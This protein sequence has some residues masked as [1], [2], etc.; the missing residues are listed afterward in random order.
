MEWHPTRSRELNGGNDDNRATYCD[1]IGIGRVEVGEAGRTG[2]GD[3][4]PHYAMD[5]ED[6]TRIW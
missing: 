1:L 4:A 6:A 2:F 5:D 3:V